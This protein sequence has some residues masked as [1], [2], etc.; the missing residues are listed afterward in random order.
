[1]ILWLFV[2]VRWMSEFAWLKLSYSPSYIY[3][4]DLSYKSAIF[5]IWSNPIYSIFK[6][7]KEALKVEFNK[8]KS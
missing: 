6:M 7:K 4:S 5:I 2:P 3:L 1:M 8:K